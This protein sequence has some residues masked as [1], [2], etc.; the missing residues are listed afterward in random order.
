MGLWN[1]VKN[2]WA[3]CDVLPYSLW[4]PQM[5]Y[6]L[7]LP[8]ISLQQTGVERLYYKTKKKQCYEVT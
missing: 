6:T 4:S 1:T 8:K 5:W 7:R 2:S 3:F